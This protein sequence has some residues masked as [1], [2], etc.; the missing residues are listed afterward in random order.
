MHCKCC[1]RAA[2]L[3]HFLFLPVD[4]PKDFYPETDYGSDDGEHSKD[5]FYD[6]GDDE[7][8]LESKQHIET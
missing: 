4:V 3:L 8:I 6:D 7:H 5:S 1:F 2:V